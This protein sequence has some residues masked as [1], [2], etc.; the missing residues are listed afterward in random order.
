MSSERLHRS[1]ELGNISAD[2]PSQTAAAC[3]EVSLLH[4]TIQLPSRHSSPVSLP[5][6][7]EAPATQ[8]D[9]FLPGL[10]AGFSDFFT[11]SGKTEEDISDTT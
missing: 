1:R 9:G 5:K 4:R 3:A 11:V 8:G 10:A 7:I 2:L 6:H